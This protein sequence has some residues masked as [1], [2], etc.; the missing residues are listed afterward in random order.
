MTVADYVDVAILVMSCIV[1]T[2]LA[3]EHVRHK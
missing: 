2:L 1:L 3:F